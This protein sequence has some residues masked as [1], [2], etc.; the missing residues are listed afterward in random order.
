M[1]L[2]HIDAISAEKVA[3]WV[4]DSE[5]PE[6]RVDISIFVNEH[7]IAQIT[8]DRD[9]VDLR[10][11]GHNDDGKHGF[12]YLFDP[13]LSTEVERKATIR[14]ANEGTQMAY[15]RCVLLSTGAGYVPAPV[16][17]RSE[18]SMRPPGPLN[19]RRLFEKSLRCMMSGMNF[20]IY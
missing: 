13:P 7:K 18:Q 17:P 8:S 2:G 12:L 1:L 5:S 6:R 11:K 3:G 20:M 19:P 4:I 14:H 15:G 16:S 10:E 9:R